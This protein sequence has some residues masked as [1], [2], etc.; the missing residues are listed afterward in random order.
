MVQSH[1]IDVYLAPFGN[2]DTR[3]PEHTIPRTSPASTRNPN[4]VYV[5]AANG[6]RFIVVVDL[7]K[8]FQDRGSETICYQ[9]KFDEVYSQDYLKYGSLKL[10]M[11]EGSEMRGRHIDSQGVRKIDGRWSKCGYVFGRLETGE[12]CLCTSD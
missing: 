3:Y 5:E 11:P 2:P 10:N 6:E 12:S 9:R 4:E 7:L 1:G 8:D